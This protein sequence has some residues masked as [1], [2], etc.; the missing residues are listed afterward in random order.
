[1]AGKIQITIEQASRIKAI[2]ELAEAIKICAK[3]L[4]VTP[5]VTVQD[6]TFHAGTGTGMVVDV[7]PDVR[8]TTIENVIED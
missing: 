6:C 5:E 2:T 8:S 3:A 1:M 4:I 7:Q